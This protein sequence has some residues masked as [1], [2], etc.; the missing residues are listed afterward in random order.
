MKC[1][2]DLVFPLVEPSAQA[3]GMR[4]FDCKIEG[5]VQIKALD[6][7]KIVGR[8]RDLV[9]TNSVNISDGELNLDLSPVYTG[10][11]SVI[12]ALELHRI[13]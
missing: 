1:T 4:V 13:P 8:H 9:I 2:Y 3:A 7:Y 12:S 6:I 10:H 5:T 11:K